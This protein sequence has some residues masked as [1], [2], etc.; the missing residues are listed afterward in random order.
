MADWLTVSFHM[1]DGSGASTWH[2]T[3]DPSRGDNIM[4]YIQSIESF[5]ARSCN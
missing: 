4:G 2:P 5:L 3:A 1:I